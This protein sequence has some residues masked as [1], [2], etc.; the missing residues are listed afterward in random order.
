MPRRSIYIL[1]DAGREQV[2]AQARCIK[3][4]FLLTEKISGGSAVRA[5][6]FRIV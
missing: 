3:W 4:K 6:S 1:E 5:E 2:Q